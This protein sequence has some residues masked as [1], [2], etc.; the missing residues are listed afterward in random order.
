MRRLGPT[1]LLIACIALCGCGKLVQIP[2][3]P[4]P[5]SVLDGVR[6]APTDDVP[7]PLLQEDASLLRVAPASALLTVHFP[8]L[9]GSIESF[10]RTTLHDLITSPE[11]RQA[12]GPLA[13]GMSMLDGGTGG[14]MTMPMLGGAPDG[15]LVVSLTDIEFLPDAVGLPSLQGVL[16]YSSPGKGAMMR[17]L[18]EGIV[19]QAVQD[20]SLR[21]ERG[22]A[23]GTEFVR[24]LGEHPV[25][26]VAELAVHGDALIVGLGRDVVTGAL[27]R[28]ADDTLPA[29]STSDP[30]NDSFERLM[31]PDDAVRIHLA[32]SRLLP[33]VEDALPPEGR[34]WI[35]GLGLGNIRSL[36]AAVRFEGTDVV[37]S[38]LI[39][40]PGGR[41]VVTRVMRGATVD[42]T[43][44]ARMPREVNSF[45]LFAVDPVRVLREARASLPD[46]ARKGLGDG[47]AQLREAGFDLERDLLSALEPQGALVTVPVTGGALSPDDAVWSPFLGSV[48]LWR[49]A[50]PERIGALLDKLPGEDQGWPRR[51]ETLEGRRV[52]VYSFGSRELPAELAL[53]ITLD[54]QAQGDVLLL[55][56]SR[57]AMR[58]LLTLPDE[59]TRARYERLLADVPAGAVVIGYD[60]VR[61]GFAQG[62]QALL[63]SIDPGMPGQPVPEIGS[64]DL[65]AMVADL[66]PGISWTVADENGVSNRSVSPTAGLGSTG[67]FGGLAVLGS[68]AVPNLTRARLRGNEASALAALRGLQAAE[69]AYSRALRRDRDHDGEGEYAFPADFGED[70]AAGPAA[71]PAGLSL[72]PNGDLR[73]YGYCFRV[74]LPAEDGS[75]IG[76]QEPEE[77]R[78]LVDGDLAESVVVLVAWP[79]HRG[80]TGNRA[81]LMTGEGEIW[82]SDDGGYGGESPPAPDVRSSQPG[83]IA[84]ARLPEDAGARDGRTWIRLRS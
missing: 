24:I 45:S 69:R 47:L 51:E 3:P 11:M 6:L 10:E 40:S 14:P 71:L 68:V 64:E 37:S 21:I 82:V 42:R 81:F 38:S 83:N 33:R 22:V 61:A 32:V 17:P 72:Q 73:G 4:V 18:L 31:H 28:L 46:T 76:A 80:G 79:V 54:D 84:A 56:L 44:L 43:L 49:V 35:E 19:A 36:T 20:R 50:K 34:Q 57:T 48:L 74:Y 58:R 63:T 2:P 65:R 66:G 5:L 59:E 9:K 16:A 55:S 30:Y 15:E 25:P 23:S 27:A 7:L 77:R 1:G 52:L 29:L 60:D 13:A 8:D 12:L 41:D 67:G 26:Y 75:P 39:D 78:A 53:C 62:M 70:P